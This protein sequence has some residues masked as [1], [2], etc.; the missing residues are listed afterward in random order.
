[1]RGR[2]TAR[3]V[4]TIVVLAGLGVAAALYVLVHERL[5]LPLRSTYDVHVVLTQA[6]GVQPSLGQPVNVAG[7][8]VGTIVGEGVDPAGNAD[9]T[10]QIERSQIPRVYTNGSAALDLITPL[11]D[12]ELDLDPGYPP[13]HVLPP[14]GTIAVGS[15]TTPVP[16][17]DLLD[18]MDSDTRDFLTSLVS[19]L[20]QGTAGRAEDLRQTLTS[21]G[22]TVAQV[23]QITGALVT[24]RV[25]LA[26]LVDN[27]ATVTQA[28]TQDHQLASVVVAG[29]QTLHALAAQDVPLQAAISKLPTTFTAARS[30]LTDTANF[31]H[32][33]T[34]TLTALL[35]TIPRLPR[36]VAKLNTL[37]EVGRETLSHEVRPLVVEAQPLVRN[38]APATVNL[39]ALAP[40]LTS[41]FQV[42][43]YFFNELA[44]VPG[45]RDQGFLFWGS[46]LLHNDVSVLQTEDAHGPIARV[47][48]FFDCASE[49]NLV[50]LETLNEL[51]KTAAGITS[52]CPAGS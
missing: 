10:A 41:V 2:S 33:L 40:S 3:F 42:L 31:A 16:L 29:D 1:M 13:A 7:V 21:L 23:H 8:Q 50:G 18:S 39:S 26:H 44:Y 52:P 36:A 20:Q 4:L 5:S 43:N 34:P 30:A 17:S 22:P 11:G 35:P 25:E 19:S 38:L 45:G 14:G 15:T 12:L 28:A 27:L 9:V 49:T 51:L 6:N 32:V 47:S 48:A 46:W 24:R 37:S